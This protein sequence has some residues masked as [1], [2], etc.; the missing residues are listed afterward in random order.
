M[1]YRSDWLLR[2][3]IDDGVYQKQGIGNLCPNTKIMP[4]KTE[5]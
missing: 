4:L 3:T 1:P 2:T 5:K